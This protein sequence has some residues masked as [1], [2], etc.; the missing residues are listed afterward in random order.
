[1]ELR[2]PLNRFAGEPINTVRQVQSWLA[3]RTAR[4]AIVVAA[5]LA[6]TLERGSSPMP[7]C[8]SHSV[9]SPKSCCRLGVRPESVNSLRTGRLQRFPGIGAALRNSRPDRESPALFRNCRKS[10]RRKTLAHMRYRSARRVRMQCR[11]GWVPPCNCR[12]IHIH[13]QCPKHIRNP[14]LGTDHNHMRRDGNRTM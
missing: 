1:M 10:I 12:L 6:G 3:F 13:N 7:G 9:A 14:S 8:N 2:R 11:I 5:E 4:S